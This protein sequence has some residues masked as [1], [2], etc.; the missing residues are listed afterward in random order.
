MKYRFGNVDL[1][2]WKVV[3]QFPRA[4]S[5]NEAHSNSFLLQHE[6]FNET[7]K[8]ARPN[9]NNLLTCGNYSDRLMLLENFSANG[10]SVHNTMRYVRR[11][12]GFVQLVLE[13]QGFELAHR[14]AKI[15]RAYHIVVAK[16]CPLL[17]EYCVTE[18]S[19]P[20]PTTVGCPPL[21]HSFLRGSV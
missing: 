3:G 1:A 20:R 2:A 18:E 10:D 12:D 16:R 19:S 17:M 14:E 11:C 7:K 6:D 8:E 4:L 21:K 5:P 15:F 13:I 9:V